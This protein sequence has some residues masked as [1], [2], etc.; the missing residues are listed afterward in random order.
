M[1]G[2][3]M[4]M[5]WSQASGS[6]TGNHGMFHRFH[7]EALTIEGVVKRKGSKKYDLE[8]L[9]R[10]LAEVYVEHKIHSLLTVCFLFVCFLFGG[11]FVLSL[12]TFRFNF[13]FNVLFFLFCT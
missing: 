4:R 13:Y 7:I 12:I 11:M 5:M 9:S 8:L 1:L 3:L 2:T 10:Y 6:P